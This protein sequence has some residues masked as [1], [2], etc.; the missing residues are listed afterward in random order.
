MVVLLLL[1]AVAGC[2][3]GPAPAPAAAA[4]REFR[5]AD[6]SLTAIPRQPRRILSTSVAIT[7][8]LLAID[9]PVVAS[10]SASNGEFF[11]QWQALARERHVRNAWPAGS[12]SLEAAMAA[13]PDLIV[14]STGGADSALEQLAAL[15][16]I[17]P[18]IV[19]DYGDQPWEQLALALGRATGLEAQATRRIDAFQRKLVAA[20]ARIAVPAGK[21]NLISYNGAGAANPVATGRSAQARLLAQLGFA[22]EEPDP[23]WQVGRD[24]RSDFVWAPYEQLSG[25]QAQTTFLLRGGDA[26]VAAF[27]DDPML[28]N[29]PSVR[30]RQV[31]ALGED[32]F[33]IDYYSACA[34]VDRLVRQVGR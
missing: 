19:L 13:R 22:I 6:G 32:A 12:V 26:R 9:A 10:A 25:L 27:L 3:E 7:G 18:T 8:T 15:R 24:P 21:A 28:A 34:I 11:A 31:Y 33:R 20:R 4:W 17:A 5:N 16:A 23:R 29:L 2:S 30:R 14:V 1:C